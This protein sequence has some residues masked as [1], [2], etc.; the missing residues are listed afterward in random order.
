MLHERH[1]LVVVDSTPVKLAPAPL[2]VDPEVAVWL[3]RCEELC[4]GRGIHFLEAQ[5]VAL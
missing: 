3:E 4:V 1:G 2:H 5:E